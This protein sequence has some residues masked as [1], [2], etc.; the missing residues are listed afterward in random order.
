[1]YLN[2]KRAEKLQALGWLISATLP[3][4]NHLQG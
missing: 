2:S 4:I 1:M 3:E